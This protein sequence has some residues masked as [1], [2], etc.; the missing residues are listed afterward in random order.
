M[1][2]GIILRLM[3]G[4]VSKLGNDPLKAHLCELHNKDKTA[5]FFSKSTTDEAKLSIKNLFQVQEVKSYEKYLGLPSF[6][7][8]GKKC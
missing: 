6:V 1:S 7:G 3:V 5:I 8:R 4:I 2:Q